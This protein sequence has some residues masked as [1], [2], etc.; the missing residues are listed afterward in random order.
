M[1]A[2]MFVAV[3]CAWIGNLGAAAPSLPPGVTNTQNPKDVPISPTEALQRMTLPEGFKATLFAGEP[4]VMQPIAFDFDDRGRLWVVE[5]FSYPDFKEQGHDRILIF[6]DKNG[7]GQFDERKV[8]LDNGHRLSGIT[9][10][11]GGVWVTSAPNLLFFPDAD[12]DD[13]P[14][15][16]PTIVLDG[17][18]LKAGHNMVNG[19]AWGPDGWLYGRH[20]ITTHSVVGK[21]GAPDIE[22]IKL[23]CSIWRYH[24]VKKIFEVVV[25]GTTNPWGLD[26][27][28]FGQPFFSNNVIGHLWHVVPGAHYKRMFGEDFNPYTYQLIEQCADHLHWAAGDW[29]KAR[30]GQDAF[31]GGH[32]HSGAMIYLGDNWPSEFRSRIMMANIHGNRLL[33]DQLVRKGSG[34]VARHGSDFLVANDRWFRA[35]QISYGPDG[36]VFVTDWNDFGE[37]HD[38][39]GSYRTSGRIYKI[40]YGAGTKPAEDFDLKKLSDGE[41]VKLQLHVN[42][43]WVRHARRILQERAATGKLA[44]GTHGALAQMVR[45]NP[46][47]TRKLRALWALHATGGLKEGAL[48]LNDPRFLKRP[49]DQMRN[50]VIGPAAPELLLELLEHKDENLRW[51]AVQLL[52]EDKSFPAMVLQRF[53]N[54]AGNESSP[55]VRLSIASA[56]QR[57]PLNARFTIARGLVSHA[58]DVNDQNLPL[59][60]WYGIES[61]V[62]A[63][64]AEALRLASQSKIPLVRELIARRVAN[65]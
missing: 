23:S 11:F 42:D 36:G 50:R 61:A 28:D 35:I 3:A 65:P 41:L 39:D 10:G 45:E 48:P 59:M 24:P 46:D 15:A 32:S 7:D 38:T 4:N 51:W 30:T 27:D 52:S 19:L 14:D 6:T 57:V 54:M 63:N 55:F 1:R 26:W 49:L 33:Y 5:C 43:W 40:T 60:I 34:Y 31:G 21:P 56:L 62:P 25:N 47:V 16:K 17:W 29:T 18:T 2:V 22:R 20:G 12:G 53:A 64:R 37:C 13:V 8:F 44:A 9:L 58:E